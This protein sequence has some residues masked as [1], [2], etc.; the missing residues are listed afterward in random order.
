MRY[1]T[2]LA[3]P[4]HIFLASCYHFESQ[5]KLGVTP[6]QQ[7][8]DY[9]HSQFPNAIHLPNTTFYNIDN[10]DFWSQ[11]SALGPACD[12]APSC[13][14][15]LGWAVKV[16]KHFNSP[17]AM[18]GGGHMPIEG[19]NNINASGV[20]LSSSGFKQLHLEPDGQ[21]LHVGPGNHWVDVY[22]FLE[23]FGKVV[24]GGRLGVV[25][26]P[27]FVISFFSWQHGWS[28]NNIKSFTGVL[29]NGE[30]VTAT[31]DNHFADLFW[32]LRGG[33]NNFMLVT[34]I[35]MTTYE[36]PVVTLGITAHGTLENGTA[37][38]G[39]YIDA[40]YDFAIHGSADDAKASIIPLIN[41][42][43]TEL[44]SSELS[45]IT[46]R[47]YDG[48]VS[49]TP[50]ALENFTTPN[51]PVVS[52]SFSPETMYGWSEETGPQFSA[53]EGLRQRFYIIPLY[54]SKEALT[55]VIKTYFDLVFDGL[56]NV[57]T[58]FTGLS[59]IPV[60]ER[61]INASHSPHGHGLPDGDPMGAEV[62]SYF[63][64]E[65]ALSYNDDAANEH[66]ITSFLERAESAIMGNLTEAGLIDQVSKFL[67]LNDADKG[68]DVWGG[69][70][71]ENV[72]KLQQIREKYDPQRVFTDLMS[73]GWKVA[74]YVVT[75]DY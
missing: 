75:D 26:V 31:P 68:Q 42:G 7:A 27:G 46:Y 49:S 30:V 56:A 63:W 38:A 37:S 66:I 15:D 1:T 24:V 14:E 71:K 10:P 17:F 53:T 13:A 74:N 23:P 3:V 8:C 29:A 51:L 72:R 40:L 70:P 73:G 12:F 21:S 22:R 43:N 59:P 64:V 39:D 47:F 19:F 61:F 65:F 55:I 52:D 57:E 60:S 4:G 25:G 2:L 6:A 58:W 45:Y 32:A 5:G 67:Y 48:N 54:A 18:R 34:D 41:T 33:G 16:L 36:A 44:F 28:S 11:A 20:L 9:L 62:S 69:Y 35:E 50:K